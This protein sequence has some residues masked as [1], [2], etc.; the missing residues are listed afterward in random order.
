[1]ANNNELELIDAAV[2]T[3]EKV[4]ETVK[5]TKT[6]RHKTITGIIAGA[7]T[8]AVVATVAYVSVKIHKKRKNQ[9]SEETEDAKEQKD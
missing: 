3:V 5:K 7:I 8:T 6:R 2:D 9:E 4:T 1:M